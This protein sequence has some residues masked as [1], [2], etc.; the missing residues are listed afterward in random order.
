MQGDTIKLYKLVR[1]KDVTGLSGTGDVA[2]IAKLPSGRCVMEWTSNHPTI[3][4]FANLDE[5][6]L[7]HGHNGSSVLECLDEPKKKGKRKKK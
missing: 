6:I 1:N 2:F 3:T 4:I 7:I 5:L